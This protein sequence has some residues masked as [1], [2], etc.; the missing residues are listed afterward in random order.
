M[1]LLRVTRPPEA[2]W[3][4]L[5]LGPSAISP[6]RLGHVDR[7]GINRPTLR[8]P[9]PREGIHLPI[10]QPNQAS[11]RSRCLSRVDLP[12]SAAQPNPRGRLP[13]RRLQYARDATGRVESGEIFIIATV[14][15]TGGRNAI[16]RLCDAHGIRARVAGVEELRDLAARYRIRAS[17]L[18]ELCRARRAQTGP[19]AT[20]PLEPTSAASSSERV[21]LGL[22][23]ATN[24]QPGAINS[25]LQASAAP[26]S[27]WRVRHPDR[28]MTAAQA[29]RAAAKAAAQALTFSFRPLRQATPL[30]LDYTTTE[31]S[32]SE[33]EEA[34]TDEEAH[35]HWRDRRQADRLAREETPHGRD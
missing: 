4:A 35:R 23:R 13:V 29:D 21:V 18:A 9:V 14:H 11:Q 16:N 32:Q 33:W 26:S 30:E 20:T 1:A 34:S 28:P 19:P 31:P 27:A 5:A 7:K 17:Y 2:K 22:S 25:A 6:L 24:A 3:P 12:L 8:A 15:G 10:L